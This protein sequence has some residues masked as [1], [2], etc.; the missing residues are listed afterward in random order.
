VAKIIDSAWRVHV[1]INESGALQTDTQRAI[2][3]FGLRAVVGI[4]NEFSVLDPAAI[5]SAHT[6]AKATP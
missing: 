2:S 4:R 3:E 5:V 1:A 6:R